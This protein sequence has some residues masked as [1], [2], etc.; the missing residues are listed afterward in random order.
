M[1]CVCVCVHCIYFL[2]SSHQNSCLLSSYSC[3][4]SITTSTGSASSITSSTG[5][6][7]SI[8]FSAGCTSS[9]ASST[10]CTSS[11]TSSTGCA[12]CVVKEDLLLCVMRER[13]VRKNYKVVC[14]YV[15]KYYLKIYIAR[16]CSDMHSRK[17]N[18]PIS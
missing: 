1:V 2:S 10:D 18:V 15:T 16:V 17:Y 13:I 11:I 5:C 14:T 4:S 6:T 12:T 9:I 3:S 7:S 8:A